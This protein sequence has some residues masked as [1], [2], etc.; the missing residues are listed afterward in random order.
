MLNKYQKKEVRLI[1]T[2]LLTYACGKCT[3]PKEC[4][5]CPVKKVM[6]MMNKQLINDP[7]WN[8]RRHKLTLSAYT[9]LKKKGEKDREIRE[10]YNMTR[11]QFSR[12]KRKEGIKVGLSEEE[13][14]EIRRLR[15]QGMF[16]KQIAKKFGISE[17]Y[18]SDI[19]RGIKFPEVQEMEE[20]Q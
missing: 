3:T 5:E 9:S 15:K 2:G 20:A 11:Q 8:E 13:V 12:F 6:Q 18:A 10:M 4:D 19:A 16:Y 17:G 14:L 1:N 7:D